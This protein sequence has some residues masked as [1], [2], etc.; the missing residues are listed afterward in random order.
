MDDF[1]K[2]SK[3][4]EELSRQQESINDTLNALTS[5]EESS[6]NSLEAL[7]DRVNA[8]MHTIGAGHEI[9][10]SEEA[11]YHATTK[12][13]IH[14]LNAD[15]TDADRAYEMN[16]ADVLVACLAGGL[17][18]IIDFIV[19]KT[20]KSVKLGAGDESKIISGSSLTAYL[21]RFGM[22]ENNKEAKWIRSLEKWFKVN[23]DQSYLDGIKGMFPKNHRAYSL[24]HEPSIMGLIWGIKDL[25]CNTSSFI[26]KDGVLRIVK[27]ADT[28]LQQKMFAPILWLGHIFSDIFTKAGL[29]IPGNSI[30]RLLQVGSFGEKER[31]IGQ[32]AEYMYLSG[33]DARHLL[34]ASTSNAAIELVIRIYL[35]FISDTTKIESE[36]LFEKEYHR[37]M[38]NRKRH[39]LLM[40][41]YSVA[42]T[43][44]I[45]KVA[46]YSGSP[47]AINI[48]IWY[49][50]AKEAV[51]KFV[52]VGSDSNFYIHAIENRDLI[53]ERFNQ[54]LTAPHVD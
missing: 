38:S 42:A 48:P 6:T 36:I 53:E 26:D 23:Y 17:A 27:T 11:P 43:G 44:N 46:A 22:S 14:P 3:P 16:R 45:A 41:A 34:T 51:T 39:N 31:T 50:F 9:D 15:K 4:I 5:Q 40:T 32:I 37:I 2:L 8:I 18:V 35:F 13:R 28:T 12:E 49:S 21:K 30:L 25:I 33:Y 7:K 54:L 19:V 47:N 20:P 1:H 24:G 52:I 10:W 29:P